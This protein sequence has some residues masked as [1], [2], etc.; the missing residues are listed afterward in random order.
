VSKSTWGWAEEQ[1]ILQRVFVARSLGWLI[2]GLWLLCRVLAFAWATLAI[3]YSNLPWSWLRL[4]FAAAFALFT[5]WAFFVSRQRRMSVAALV[6]L[7]G[8]AVWWI[9]IPPSHDRNWRPE[10][11]VMPRAFI[12]S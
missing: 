6:L 10:V 4:A 8:V 2:T 9:S 5:I 11:A 1:R 12:D 7:L 3:Y